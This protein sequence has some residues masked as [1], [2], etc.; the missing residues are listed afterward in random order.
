MKR[1]ELVFGTILGSFSAYIVYL[2]YRKRDR[3]WTIPIA[4]MIGSVFILLTTEY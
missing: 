4:G 3:L 1:K 2:V